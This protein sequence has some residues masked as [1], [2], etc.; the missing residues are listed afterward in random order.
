MITGLGL[1]QQLP[2]GDGVLPT[3]GVIHLW[4][5]SLTLLAL[6]VHSLFNFLLQVL[7]PDTKFL[8]EQVSIFSNIFYIFLCIT[9]PTSLQLTNFTALLRQFRFFRTRGLSLSFDP[10]TM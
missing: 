1:T 6:V 4:N 2:P 3:I 5:V 7:P 10:Q 9:L 8:P